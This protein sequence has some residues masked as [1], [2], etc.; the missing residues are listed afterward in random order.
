MRG[1]KMYLFENGPPGTKKSRLSN[2]NPKN[3]FKGK[4]FLLGWGKSVS[5]IAAVRK[6]TLVGQEVEGGRLSDSASRELGKEEG[7]N[8]ERT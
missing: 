2:F 5:K 3:F 4:K 8:R 7:I 6:P 1:E